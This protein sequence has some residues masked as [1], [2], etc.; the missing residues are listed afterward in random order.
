MFVKRQQIVDLLTSQGKVKYVNQAMLRM[1][2]CLLNVEEEDRVDCQGLL[3]NEWMKLYY[4]KYKASI[5]K[6]T[7]NQMVKNKRH[8]EIRPDF[9]FYEC[10]H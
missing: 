9:P 8:R 1:L 10:I 7:K 4:S 5:L 2:L 6:K 3:E